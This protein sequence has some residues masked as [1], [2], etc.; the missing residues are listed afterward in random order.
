MINDNRETIK[1]KIRYHRKKAKMS[2]EQLGKLVG[3]T[4]QVVSLWENGGSIPSLYQLFKIARAF[5]TSIDIILGESKDVYTPIFSRLCDEEL[6]IHKRDDQTY[7]EGM[8]YDNSKEKISLVPMSSMVALARVLESGAK[9]YGDNNWKKGILYSRIY[10]AAL[11]HLMQFWEI[12]KY[13]KDS[14]LS[15]LWHA[16][17]NIAMLI[18]YEE[19]PEIY[20]KFDDNERNE[21]NEN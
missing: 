12:E 7:E 18:Y 17:T 19:Y 9:K 13:D 16:I 15:H 5:N 10:S 3:V 1:L 14:D 4:R 8:K 11:R 6:K 2:Q 20:N 21:K